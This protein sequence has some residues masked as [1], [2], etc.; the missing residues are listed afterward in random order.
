M[1]NCFHGDQKSQAGGGR[2]RPMRPRGIKAARTRPG[3]R[4]GAGETP[5]QLPWLPG[6]GPGRQDPPPGPA[7]EG[8]AETSGGA[9]AAT[10]GPAQR[11]S[12]VSTM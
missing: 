5:R 12:I 1:I 2:E 8:Q 6:S 11:V 7:T 10:S 3:L 9:T 4:Q